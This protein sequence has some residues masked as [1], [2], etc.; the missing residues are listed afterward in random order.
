[1]TQLTCLIDDLWREMRGP[2]P[3]YR[4]IQQP[5]KQTGSLME[6]NRATPSLTAT[7]L[8]ASLESYVDVLGS[9]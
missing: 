3:E 7:D 1:M 4:L 8:G 5:S 2:I 9:N 6:P